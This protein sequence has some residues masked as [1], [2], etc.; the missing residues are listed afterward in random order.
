M[1]KKWYDHG[2]YHIISGTTTDSRLLRCVQYIPYTRELRVAAI[3]TFL[4]TP[5]IKNTT[6]AVAR[7]KQGFSIYQSE[8]FVGL[9]CLCKYFT[10]LSAAERARQRANRGK[11]EG[12]GVEVSNPALSFTAS[13]SHPASLWS[14]RQDL[15]VPRE[16]PVQL[17]AADTTVA[18]SQVSEVTRNQWQKLWVGQHVTVRTRSRYISADSIFD[19]HAHL[20]V[21]RY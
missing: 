19:A 9:C 15:H 12:G 3:T 5:A 18:S 7:L 14:V 10:R 2:T 4:Q 20:P 6:F 17:G 1:I 8:R 21:L 16:P 11:C 13:D